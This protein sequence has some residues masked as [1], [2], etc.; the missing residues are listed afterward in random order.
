MSMVN[1][2]IGQE[3]WKKVF[4]LTEDILTLTSPTEQ[5]SQV[6][7]S[8]SGIYNARIYIWLDPDAYRLPGQIDS[9]IR[10]SYDQTA[11]MRQAV[12]A[13]KVTRAH[14]KSKTRGYCVAAPLL[15]LNVLIGAIQI[16]RDSPLTADEID[17]L[18][19]IASAV[20][21]AMQVTRQNEKNKWRI[22]QLALVR[23][24]SSQITNLTDL[25]ELTKR[26]TRLIC[27]TF[28][29]YCVGIFTLDPVDG[30]LH[31]QASADLVPGK[32]AG[33][34]PYTNLTIQP[35]EGIIGHVAQT[36]TELVSCKVDEEPRYRFL[37]S[38]PE[39]QSEIVLP[40]VIE[41][42]ILGVLDVQSLEVNAFHEID[43]LVL[44]AL[45]DNIALAVEG[46]HMVHD[47]RRRAEQL[48][49][50]AEVSRSLSSILN[51]DALMDEV[52]QIIQSRFEFP[53]VSLFSVHPGRKKIYFLAGTSPA[54]DRLREENFSYDLEDPMGMIPYASRNGKTI[55]AADVN[56]E[57]LYRITRLTSRRTKSEMT[58]PLVFAGEVHGVLDLQSDQPH[59]F[60]DEDRFLFEALGDSIAIIMRNAQIYESE[61]W[62]RQV[63][64]SLR[65]VAGLL[66]SEAG[67]DQILDKILTELER[68][69]PCEA[70][71]I[72]LLEDNAS[73]TDG[74][75]AFQL[76]LA[77]AHGPSHEKLQQASLD[78]P[79]SVYLM[80]RALEVNHPIVRTVE[81]PRGPLGVASG[82][83]P[84]YSAI[85]APLKAGESPLG[86]LSLAHHASGRYGSEALSMTSTFASYA[87]VAIE[88]NRL[89]SASQEQAWVSTVMLQ[90]TE[91]A[92][93]L[94]T[95]EELLETVVRITPMLAGVQSSSVFLFDQ[96]SQ[97]FNLTSWY[98][99][100]SAQEEY[101][102]KAAIYPGYS[103]EFDQL[104]REMAPLFINPETNDS[105]NIQQ[106]V[107]FPLIARSDL[108]GAFLVGRSTDQPMQHREAF[109]EQQLAI[110]QGIVHQT[111]VAAENIR[112]L[113]SKQEEAYVTAVLLQVAQAVVSL[114]N[115]DEILDTIVHLMPILIG[116]DASAFFLW[117]PLRGVYYPAKV[118]GD[119]P[120][121]E[122]E[123]LAN[124]YK[125]GDFPLLDAV[126]NSDTFLVQPLE[127]QNLTPECW[128][129]VPASETRWDYTEAH[130]LSP[131]LLL[132]FPLTVKGEFYGA[133]LA[134]EN[135]SPREGYQRR[136]EIITGVAQ[137]AALAVQDDRLQAETIVRERLE[138]EI[139]LARQIQQTFLP[140]EVV[141]PPGWNLDVRW[142][143]AR[144]VGG[145]FYDYFSLPGN[146]LAMVVADVSDKGM[147]AAL[148][149]TVARTLIRASAQ[150]DDSPAQILM[151]V[152]DLLLGDTQTGMFVTAI[153]AEL[154]LDSGDIVYVNAGHNLPV[155]R[156]A[157][158]SVEQLE[159]GG[160]ALGAWEDITL[161]N[162]K[163][164]LS[165][166]DCLLFYTDGVT[167]AFSTEDEPF[168]D[169]RLLEAVSRSTDESASSILA[170]VDTA[171]QEFIGS[172]PPSDDVTMLAVMRSGSRRPQQ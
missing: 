125:P 37:K 114:D 70:S 146:R 87:A 162:R 123:I 145:D 85:I 66:S 67:Q 121:L 68:N 103:S 48:A 38:L 84:D 65:D 170:S 151:R 8:L 27:D 31:F 22:E 115:L 51:P 92:Q 64:E 120:S 54:S 71:A 141:S 55:I 21:L 97:S 5:C 163:L 90:I 79:E 25:Q 63:A 2:Q 75:S 137:Q 58:V 88:N 139:Q 80:Q 26:V 143:T 1:L 60:S 133:L 153:Y 101:Y 168:G 130:L 40:L 91:A 23:S 12:A 62:R 117:D 104:R 161:V 72:W 28:H 83:E 167:E 169:Q 149:M 49:T 41:N 35:G 24:V 30:A 122:D 119:N 110:L 36:G 116:V 111:A 152:N 15:A 56:L 89:Y 171:L 127:G 19:A 52:V 98:G 34:N 142:R 158:G 108:I 150:E 39:T 159:K 47:L 32:D 29:F 4:Q 118:L 96:A 86:I 11:L 147:P 113:D 166:G 102:R 106:S 126:K 156:R 138:R 135:R 33:V 109:S 94:G 124:I 59:A 50:V 140:S 46:A 53:F 148:Y 81:E 154:S 43:I 132:A 160:V 105:G 136:L 74:Q 42:R 172:N 13:G 18:D 157:G 99:L 134:R 44:R 112:L 16:E 6:E 129:C 17:R 155:L 73:Q 107:L 45:A 10:C 95:M 165:S 69:L 144:Q 77:A 82:F 131:N 3:N 9:G 57:P 128:S 76:R 78:T 20:A 93:S 14:G 7:R 61:R 100:D 164:N